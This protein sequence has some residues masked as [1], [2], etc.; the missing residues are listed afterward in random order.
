MH[1]AASTLV[2][3]ARRAANAGEGQAPRKLQMLTRFGYDSLYRIRS[4]C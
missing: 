3:L 4:I 2:P 1:D